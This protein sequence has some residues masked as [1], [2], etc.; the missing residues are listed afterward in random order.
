MFEKEATMARDQSYD[1]GRAWRAGNEEEGGYG[2]SGM[3]GDDS[4]LHR[5]RYGRDPR[6]SSNGGVEYR[7]VP[8][9]GRRH[10]T[11]A[12]NASYGGWEGNEGGSHA[13]RGPKNYRRSDERIA[14]EINEALTRNPFL[15]PS[16]VEVTVSAG[17]VT[18]EGTVDSRSSKRLAEEIADSVR[19]V[20]D[21]HNRL[22][23]GG[24]AARGEADAD[25]VDPPTL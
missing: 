10:D 8:G 5:P 19:G 25:P 16:D 6:G 1:R 14:E 17:E 23:L 20:V 9:R 11:D 15:D 13:G 24:A 7:S 21:V 4:V 2:G 12:S 22:K 3:E 18:L